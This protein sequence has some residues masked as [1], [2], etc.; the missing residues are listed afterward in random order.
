MEKL[1]RGIEYWWRSIYWY[2]DCEKGNNNNG[3]IKY[4]FDVLNL[5]VCIASV[6]I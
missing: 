3:E 6:F 2:S 5:S 4:E 1:I